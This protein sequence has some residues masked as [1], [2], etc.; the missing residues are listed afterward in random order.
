MTKKDYIP[1]FSLSIQIL[2]T[3]MSKKELRELVTKY[4]KAK[5]ENWGKYNK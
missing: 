1:K 2:A 5:K 3:F 4:V